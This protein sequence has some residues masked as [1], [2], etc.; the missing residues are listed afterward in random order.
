MK[1]AIVIAMLLVLLVLLSGPQSVAQTYYGGLR[2]TVLDPTGQAI[3]SA[4]V[5]LKDEATNVER[6]VITNGD[7]EYVFNSVDP[8]SYAVPVIANG[9]KALVRTGAVISTQQF[10]TLDF[11]VQLGQNNE[12]V[13]VIEDVPLVESSNASNG[14]V[15]DTQKLADLPNLG[16][17]PFLFRTSITNVA[18]VGDPRFN[19]F[20]DQ[21]GSSQISI[22]GV[23]ITDSLNRAVIIPSIEAPQ[24][25][26]V[27]ANTYD[28]PM[29]RTG[30]GVFNT[31]L[32][33]GPRLAQTRLGHD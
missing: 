9:F 14:Q 20:Q 11:N 21:S 5:K 23:P 10:L 12:I 7:G 22:A 32:K 29:G 13:Q 2:G 31:T 16:R 1:I 8:A 17:N 30:G 28:A 27:Q 24:E 33:S 25:V 3:A 19:R 18:A 26:K 15:I 4:T 6:S